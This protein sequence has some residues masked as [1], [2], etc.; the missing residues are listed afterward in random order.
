MKAPGSRV[1]LLASCVLVPCVP[2]PASAQ[3][4]I[5]VSV[6][7]AGF[8]PETLRLRKGE[9]VRISLRTLD[10]EHCFAV[11]A[12]RVEKRIRPDRTT[13]FELTP[14]KAGRFPIYCCLEPEDT[15]QRGN[16]VVAE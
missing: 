12:L 10:E 5:D 15:A 9:S 1:L 11:D 6:S 3:E 4:G 2:G 13:S 8:K 16:M 14:D 7:K